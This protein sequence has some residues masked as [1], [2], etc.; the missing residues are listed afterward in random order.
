[1]GVKNIGLFSLVG[2]SIGQK[3]ARFVTDS[4]IDKEIDKNY[5]KVRQDID[6]WWRK[7]YIS[8][9]ITIVTNI[10]IFV[11]ALLFVLVAPHIMFSLMISVLSI[12][13]LCRG[14]YAII[15]FI[16][17]VYENRIAVREYAPIVLKNIRSH[18]LHI[19]AVIE[20]SVHE[21]F[22]KVY[23]KKTNPLIRFGHN[24]LA[25]F[26]VV[27]SYDELEDAVVQLVF[28]LYRYGL[29]IVFHKTIAF[30][31][32]I[33]IFAAILKPFMI[34]SALHMNFF[35]ILLYPFTVLFS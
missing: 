18:G 6:Y 11:F 13:L 28:R 17:W 22:E 20:T 9:A 25:F 31:F 8:M 23:Y 33:F 29:G 1:M 30:G 10:L 2:G 14:V 5:Q 32:F 27:K 12:F 21:I 7:A 3:I 34:S 4:L 16:L 24:S 35:E 15:K 26:G 19:T